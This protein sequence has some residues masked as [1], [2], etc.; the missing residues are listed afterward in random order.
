MTARYRPGDLDPAV[1]MRVGAAAE[2]RQAEGPHPSP[3]QAQ[4][5]SYLMEPKTYPLTM[6]VNGQQVTVDPDLPPYAPAPPMIG[7]LH[8][9]GSNT[10]RD[11]VPLWVEIFKR[12]HPAVAV[13]TALYGSGIAP[14]AL[15]DGEAQVGPMGREMLPAEL[16]QRASL[17]IAGR[18]SIRSHNTFSKPYRVCMR[19]KRTIKMPTVTYLPSRCASSKAAGTVVSP[20]AGRTN[21]TRPTRAGHGWLSGDL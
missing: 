11:V 15:M 17:A 13:H 14:A 2:A 12:A 8:I 10:M 16:P 6:T 21:R 4:E 9:V 19:S 5:I 1:L 20:P 18:S 3:Y 7:E